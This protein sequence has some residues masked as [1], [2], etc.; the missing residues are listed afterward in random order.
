MPTVAIIARRPFLSSLSFSS[1]AYGF[2]VGR[3]RREGRHR[4]FH[5]CMSRPKLLHGSRT[6]SLVMLFRRSLPQPRSH[7]SSD[8]KVLFRWMNSMVPMRKSTCRCAA[9]GTSDSASNGLPALPAMP[10]MCMKLA[11]KKPTVASMATRPCL[12]SAAR[13]YVRSPWL[14]RPI[15]SKPTS[16]IMEPSSFS[17][18]SRKGR[19]LDISASTATELVR[20]ASLRGAWKAQAQASAAASTK[21]RNMV[22]CGAV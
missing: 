15:G 3:G 21:V 14:L 7:G 6:F 18:F 16:P 11:T 5:L 1:S 20:P 4:V 13:M 8:V 2:G 17:G 19:D 9:S 12:I 10:G 22:T